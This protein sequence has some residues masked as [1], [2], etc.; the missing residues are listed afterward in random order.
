MEG[1]VRSGYLAVEALLNF[2]GTPRKFTVADLPVEGF[3][4]RWAK[5]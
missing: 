4:Q 2:A 5:E 1:A 3:C